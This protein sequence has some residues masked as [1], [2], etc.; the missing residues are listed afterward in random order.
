MA[1]RSLELDRPR[2]TTRQGEGPAVLILV[3]ASALVFS[4]LYLASD[5]IELL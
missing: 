1:T 3:G 2:A 4:L 5:V